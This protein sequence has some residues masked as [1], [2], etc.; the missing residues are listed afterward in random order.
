MFPYSGGE[1]FQFTGDDDVWVF[2][3]S[4][5]AIDLGGVHSEL[6]SGN[7]DLDTNA[8]SLGISIG[9]A[10]DLDFFQCERQTTGSNFKLTTT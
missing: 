8:G 6:S 4:N 7:Y 3:N 10:Y 5:L 1:T 2:I 9:N